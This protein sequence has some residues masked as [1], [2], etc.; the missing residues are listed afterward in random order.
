MSHS[1]I[2]S[3]LVEGVLDLALST[4]VYHQAD[5]IHVQV[6]ILWVWGLTNCWAVALILF[7]ELLQKSQV[8]ISELFSVHWHVHIELFNVAQDFDVWIGFL[9]D[10]LL[11]QFLEIFYHL[12]DGIG[13]IGCLSILVLL[14]KGFIKWHWFFGEVLFSQLLNLSFND[15]LFI[16]VEV[17]IVAEWIVVKNVQI[18]HFFQ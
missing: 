11:A 18:R 16:Q 5:F 12:V 6:H 17:F 4:R 9:L 8:M 1:V 14:L 2:L 3:Y 10:F 13:V 15:K 7:H